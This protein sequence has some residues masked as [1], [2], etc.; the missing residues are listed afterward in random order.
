MGLPILNDVYGEITRL[1]AAGSALA[2]GDLGIKKYIPPLK[3]L[4][5]KAPVFKTLAE[6]LETLLGA[7]AKDSPEALMDAGML[8]ASLRYTQGTAGAGAPSPET[9]GDAAWAQTPLPV[10][11]LSY[12]LL[13]QAASAL[14]DG[15][16]LGPLKALSAS[17]GGHKD[18]RLFA[19]YCRAALAEPPAPAGTYALKRLIPKAGS[20]VIPFIQAALRTGTGI[21]KDGLARARLETLVRRLQRRERFDTMIRRLV[22]AFLKR[23][24]A[25]AL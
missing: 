9:G 20:P 6:R 13:T 8:L 16:P 14:A 3:R 7:S 10:T 17:A 22:P 12:S 24:K 11:S 18:P 5:E 19:L 1:A 2:A 21:K 15:G 4:G 25:P 23:G